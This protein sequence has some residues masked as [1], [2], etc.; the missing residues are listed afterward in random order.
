VEASARG[1]ERL[2]E[3]RARAFQCCCERVS[4]EKTGRANGVC[5]RWALC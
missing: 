4:D 5:M 3:V 1:A 2:C